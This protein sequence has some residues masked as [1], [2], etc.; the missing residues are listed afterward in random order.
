MR[1][2]LLVDTDVG[3]DDAVALIMAFRSPHVDVAAVTTV[4]G[5]VPAR[6]AATNALIVAELCRAAA[7]VY[8]GAERPLQRPYVDA[9]FFH[10]QDGLGDQHYPG[11]ERQPESDHAVDAIIAAA[12]RHPGLVLVTLGPLTNVALAV[13][14][15]PDIVRRISRCVVMGGAA[16]T[17]GNVT[18]AAEY[19]VWVD[20]DAARIV[21]LSGL[22]VEMVGWEFCRGEFALTTDEIA[23]V[24][25]L[26]TP[27]ARFAVDCNTVAMKSYQEQTGEA[28]L[29]LPDAVAMAVVL[30]PTVAT[31]TAKHYVEVE[32]ASELTRGMTVVDHLGVAE[33][34][35]NRDTWRQAVQAGK[36]VSVTWA[37]DSPRWKQLLFDRLA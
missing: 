20:P 13:L 10:G 37:V 12:R 21:F 23:R 34:A 14:Q 7:P 16:C 8:V 1:D 19:N 9:T 26:G 15:A 18:A 4:S 2:V 6:L 24:R 32:V 28:G 3:S 11:P 29:S 31:R 30:D 25:L 35:R 33:D 5:N 36:N 22:P 27:F 17:Y